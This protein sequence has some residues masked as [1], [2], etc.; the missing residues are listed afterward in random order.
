MPPSLCMSKW[1]G[2]AI[3]IMY[4]TTSAPAQ[5]QVPVRLLMDGPTGADRQVTGL[6][7]PATPD[8]AMSLD[9]LHANV[10]TH[11]ITTGSGV[12]E[13]SLSPAPAA[14]TAGMIVH[15][16]PQQANAASAM[17]DLNG[18]GAKPMVKWGGVPLDSADLPVNIPARLIYDGERFL[19][20][21]N[22]Y[23]PCPAG[24]TLIDRNYCI[25]DSAATSPASYFG[26]VTACASRGARLCTMG[27][28]AHA[29]RTT[30]GFLATVTA[31][32]W[33]EHASNSASDAKLLGTGQTAAAQATTEFGC[34]Y[35]STAGSTA[36]RSYRCCTTR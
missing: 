6:A 19:L 31:L 7:D 16:R 24:T 9:A 21:S 22:T 15:I 14:Y 18:L 2:C 26:A 27:E 36:I 3:I 5:W 33:A 12:L 1:C 30:P 17:L 34:T 8:A 25:E 32:E 28:W 10:T 4:M 29:C 13:G 20:L 35:G 11:T 23:T